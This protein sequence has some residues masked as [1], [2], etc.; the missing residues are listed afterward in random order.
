MNWWE[1]LLLGFI[2]GVLEF[3]PI[4]ST[5]HL[6]VLN[7]WLEGSES[8]LF[9]HIAS[10]LAAIVYFRHDCKNIMYDFFLYICTKKQ[11]A[12]SN[13]QVG[14]LILFSTMITLTAGNIFKLLIETQTTNALIG[15]SSI[16]TGIFLVLTEHGVEIGRKKAQHIN[17]KDAIIIGLGQALAFIPGFSRTGST[18][19]TAL[20]CGFD[21]ETALRYSFLISIPT[22]GGICL[23][24]MPPMSSSHSSIPFLI[25]LFSFLT[26]FFC[27]LLGIRL[28]ISIVRHTKL[29]YVAFYCFSFGL[30]VWLFI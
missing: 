12:K 14:L 2:H 4:S 24:Q 21:K 30:V 28:L 23:L 13:Y 5:G 20:W 7:K 22:I 29:T 10:L 26:A 16:L 1:G 9:L 15:A 3:L 19:I 17:W 6:F 27:S 11:E 25:L 18:L 8:F